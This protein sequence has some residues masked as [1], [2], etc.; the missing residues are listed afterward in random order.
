MS[1]T[2]ITTTTSCQK[3]SSR[4]K[5]F[6]NDHCYIVDFIS[7]SITICL[8]LIILLPR[9][10]ESFLPDEHQDAIVAD[11][12]PVAPSTI[13]GVDLLNAQ[14]SL[15][16]TN[17][18]AIDQT[19]QEQE[20]LEV[21]EADD[22]HHGHR[23]HHNHS[24]PAGEMLICIGFFVFYC[25]G[26][27]IARPQVTGVDQDLY[28]AR[29]RKQSISCC[30]SSRC[31]APNED[32]VVIQADALSQKPIVVRPDELTTILSP[33]ESLLQQQAENDC[34]M[35]LNRHHQHHTHSKHHEH[36]PAA[37]SQASDS[38]GSQVRQRKTDYG[39][40]QAPANS[41]RVTYMDEHMQD[42]AIK[43]TPREHNNTI[44]MD[45]IRITSGPEIRKDQWPHSLKLLSFT[46]IL[47]LVLIFFDMNVMGMIRAVKVFRATS[48][49]ALLYI[50]FFI[51]LPQKPASCSSCEE[52]EEI[53]GN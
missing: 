52:E 47:A 16:A 13:A 48:T 33:D 22:G 4:F 9:V 2:I 42:E 39:S 5:N 46:I 7:A 37:T 12:Q 6:L 38:K 43:V 45:E 44:V 40:T 18:G 20:G 41:S 31:P 15:N 14:A 50:A 21:K 19:D 27:G 3:R 34:L 23:H 30:T 11:E 26:L 32:L 25:A 53:V 10:H 35:L 1:T 24:F 28:L 51:M 8:C 29:R 36:P 49:G 17:S